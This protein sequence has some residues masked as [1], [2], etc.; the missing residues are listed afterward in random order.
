LTN[1][2]ETASSRL[3]AAAGSDQRSC[4]STQ[5]QTQDG[6]NRRRLGREQLSDY[7]GIRD[8]AAYCWLQ[9]ELVRHWLAAHGYFWPT[10]FDPV[11]ATG[12]AASATHN[13]V[14][15]AGLPAGAGPSEEQIK[16]SPRAGYSQTK[17]E[18]LKSWIAKKYPNDVP[19]N[20]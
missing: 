17:R 9:R 6:V 13:A 5:R 15:P 16:R 3:S 7:V 14:E 1:R 2:R 8:L 10:H 18:A 19:V 12:P 11:A 4:T 20:A